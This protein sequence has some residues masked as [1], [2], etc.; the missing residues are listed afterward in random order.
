MIQEYLVASS[1]AD[2]LTLKRNN[3]K[4]VWF[5]GGTEINRMGGTVDAKVGISLK[6]L[7][8][9]Q[10]VDGARP[11]LAWRLF[12]GDNHARLAPAHPFDQKGRGQDGLA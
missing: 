4:S 3:A 5:A 7:G 12:E 11:G 10:I 9:D 8:L 1:I 2:A 6:G